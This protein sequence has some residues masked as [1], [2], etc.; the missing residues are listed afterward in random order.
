ML[1]E[2]NPKL[3][4]RDKTVTKDYY[5]NKLG[6]QT[7]ISKFTFLSSKN[8]TQR[9]TMDK[10]ISGQLKLINSTIRF[11]TTKFLFTQTDN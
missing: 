3:P 2:I 5:L 6:F 8:L 1:T 9:K 11:W 7:P 10:F 4:M